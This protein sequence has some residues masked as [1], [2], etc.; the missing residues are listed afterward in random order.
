[1]PLWDN[2]A[3]QYDSFEKKWLHYEKIATGLLE[4]LEIRED[5]NILKLASGTGA[6]SKLLGAISK[7]ETIIGIDSSVEMVHI[8][9][10]NMTKSGTFERVLCYWRCFRDSEYFSERSI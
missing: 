4:Q 10:E 7:N 8:A 2:S 3:W 1:M 6:C 9:K 5:S